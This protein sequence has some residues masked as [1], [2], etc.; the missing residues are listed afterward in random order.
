MEGNEAVGV[1]TPETATGLN[2][3]KL[4][5]FVELHKEKRDLES[6]LKRVDNELGG[7]EPILREQFAN[8]GIQNMNMNGLCTYV[9]RSV[10]PKY[11]DGMERGD[12][13][14]ALKADGLS[15]ILKEDYNSQTFNAL[16][17]DIE[18]SGRGL[19]ENLAMVVEISE[20]FELRT[21]KA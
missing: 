4:A 17:R 14:E 1:L 2:M 20:K 9:N 5:R 21:R 11:R 16:I 3:G 10:Y 15:D 13:I 7:L 12:V 18:S 6:K 19:P 8:A